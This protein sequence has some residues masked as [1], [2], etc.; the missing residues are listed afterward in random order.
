LAETQALHWNRRLFHFLN[1]YLLV[2]AFR[3]F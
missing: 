3:S 1:G 2:L